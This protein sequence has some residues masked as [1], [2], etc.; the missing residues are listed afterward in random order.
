MEGCAEMNTQRKRIV[1]LAAT[2]VIFLIELLIA[3]FVR[4]NFIR[5]YVGDMLVVVLIYTC[6]RIL[7]PEKP[8]LLPLYVFL[9]AALA[10][11][12]QAINIVELLGL[13]NNRFFRILIGTTF[14]W[15][16]IACYGVGCVLCGMWEVWLW[17]RE[18]VN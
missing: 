2:I 7:I 6:L 9:F 3:L 14:D 18:K 4:D 5:P 16:D 12:L 8:R 17:N 10:E 11:G 1:Y 13:S 15:K